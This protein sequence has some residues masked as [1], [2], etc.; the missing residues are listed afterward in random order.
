MNELTGLF[1]DLLEIVK[2][3]LN[4]EREATAEQQRLVVNASKEL[5]AI[6]TDI[7]LETGGRGVNSEFGTPARLDLSPLST[8][9]LAG[10]IGLEIGKQDFHPPRLD[11]EE[12]E[13]TFP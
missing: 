11:E 13:D 12:S 3:N 5:R 6:L 4:T 1:L 8:L 2:R 10:L 7:A 9:E